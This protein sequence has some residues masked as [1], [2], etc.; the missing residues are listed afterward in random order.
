VP[1]GI[2]T[3]TTL[4]YFTDLGPDESGGMVVAAAGETELW[5]EDGEAISP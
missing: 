2:G 4:I 1:F 3:F 5:F